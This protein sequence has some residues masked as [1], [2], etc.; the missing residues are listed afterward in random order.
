MVVAELELEL[1]AAFNFGAAHF[2]QA[3]LTRSHILL[4]SALI[5]E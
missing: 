2:N 1:A 3:V 5:A 4:V